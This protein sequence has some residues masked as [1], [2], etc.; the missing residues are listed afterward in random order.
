MKSPDSDSRPDTARLEQLFHQAVELPFDEQSAF[1]ARACEGDGSL[2]WAL[3]ALLASARDA[4]AAWEGTALDIEARHSAL[5]SRK[6][7]PGE[8]F[9][10][11]R[12]VR[13]I[14]T[15]GMSFVYEALRDDAEYHKRVAIKFAL[16]SIGD[17]AGVQRF[18]TERQILA[19]L[20]HPNI[21]R[22]LDGGTTADG[23]PFL[24]ME[25]VDGVAVDHFAT[26]R[27][28][29]RVDRLKLWLQIC[30][31]VQ[32]AHRNLVVH[33]DLKPGNILVT[34]EAVPKLLDFGI[35]KLLTV[36]SGAPAATL[37]A[38][39]PEYASP[40]QVLG[41]SITTSTD[42]YSLGVL[43]F[44]LLAGR[45]PYLADLSHPAD[46]VRAIC[47]D[48]PVW[49]PPGLIQG[50]LRS[51][52]ARALHKQ[53]ER[54]YLSAEQIAADVRRY[55]DGRPV[56]AR[57]ESF[58]YR[59]RKFV[60]RHAIP[61]AAVSAVLLAL[62]AGGLSTLVQS[63]RAERRFKEVRSLAHSILFDVYDSIGAVPGSL[64]A[65]RLLAGRA[66]QYLD[67]LARDAGDDSAL[68]LELAESYLR[69]GQVRGAPYTA[70]LGETAGAIQS[71]RKALALLEREAARH[72]NDVA[73]EKAL[74]LAYSSLAQVLVRQKEPSAT[75]FVRRSI[76]SAE[77]LSAR[78][79]RDPGYRLD[80]S[81]A[82]V[83]LGQALKVEADR[84][85][86]LAA[87][88]QALAAHRK[89]VAI[90]EA[91]GPRD[92]ASWLNRLAPKY[93]YVGYA[94]RDLGE[95]TGDV[96]Y[97]RQA[98][99]VSRKGSALYQ[100]LAAANPTQNNLRNV[101]DGLA[102]TGILRWQCCRDLAGAM[103]D[104]DQAVNRFQGI[105]NADAH[106]LEAR[107]DVADACQKIGVVMAEAGRRS[108]ALA[109]DRKA[110]SI[111][112]ELGRADP[113]SRENADYIADVRARLAAL[114]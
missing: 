96:S 27:R 24:V 71:Y 34:P 95:R 105:S 50:D 31:A 49:L 25:Y 94:L 101:A 7:Q 88:Q 70:N 58:L 33:R 87:Y 62:L 61:L 55:M 22:L 28:L 78:F 60:V 47:E 8:F 69:L 114:K 98:L 30:D 113:T 99:D 16:Q 40:E 1:V 63:R 79:P 86:S 43:L 14:A 66:Q 42:V 81:R 46:L 82:Y 67:S 85:R 9:G 80:I 65:R 37:Q 12:I 64:D 104:L 75:D 21:A 10:P 45:L 84:T 39:T 73:V 76:A 112:E 2:H 5:D 51:I 38:L 90:H 106:N 17:P 35:A 11:Y 97:Y 41:R 59:A 103:R 32:Y 68:A 53:P 54:R 4:P 111:Y 107:R 23:V 3:S 15:G 74:A 44:V 77:A 91:T 72:P 83:V 26:E 109:A 19:G 36:D 92:D 108:E 18:R 57:P 13:R 110:L 48:E 6:A 93:F 89:S 102:D 52:L 100:R 56:L 20:E 29:S